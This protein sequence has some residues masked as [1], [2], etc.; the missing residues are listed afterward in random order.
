MA[1]LP[2]PRSSDT[3]PAALPA[4]AALSPPRTTARWLRHGGAGRGHEPAGDRSDTEDG[5]AAAGP[6]ARS[7]GDGPGGHLGREPERRSEP[8][9]NGDPSLQE[10][11]LPSEA[12]NR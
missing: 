6:S 9:G 3:R 7:G 2:S 4:G 11:L 10:D 8:T 5:L 12:K 1:P